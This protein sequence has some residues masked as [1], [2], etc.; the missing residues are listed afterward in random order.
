MKHPLAPV[1][2]KV[3]TKS[4][5]AT[6]TMEPTNR[7]E[8]SFGPMEGGEDFSDDDGMV[9]ANKGDEDLED[10]VG[11]G[12]EP[13]NV[14]STTPEMMLSLSINLAAQA[15]LPPPR[16]NS[17]ARLAPQGPSGSKQQRTGEQANVT[18]SE[19]LLPGP[20]STPH[21]PIEDYKR[22]YIA[23]KIM[24]EKHARYTMMTSNTGRRGWSQ[25]RIGLGTAV[26]CFGSISLLLL[27]AQFFFLSQYSDQH[28]EHQQWE[29][30][31]QRRNRRTRQV[32]LG[33]DGAGRRGSEA[34]PHASVLVSYGYYEKDDIQLENFDFFLKSGTGES[35]TNSNQGPWTLE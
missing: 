25:R 17:G 10:D 28:Q 29:R 13:M 34:Y 32:E 30:Q 1:P 5:N 26:I 12:A 9:F 23:D 22:V 35:A 19:H 14:H 3:P 6:S 20:S 31:E 2:P 11:V 16:S 7:V 4:Q 15:G 8:T 33:A 18:V 21:V 27:A 24:A